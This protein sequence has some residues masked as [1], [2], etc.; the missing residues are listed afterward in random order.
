MN[1]PEIK[2]NFVPFPENVIDRPWPQTGDKPQEA[3]S[4]TVEEMSAMLLPALIDEMSDGIIVVGTNWHIA[5][6]NR[7]AATMCGFETEAV[8]G[9]NYH[10]CMPAFL[11]D[12]QA[13]EHA[14]KTKRGIKNRQGLCMPEHCHPFWITSSVHLLRHSMTS[15]LAGAIIKISRENPA[16]APS[17]T[18]A[19]SAFF[20]QLAHEF[21][22]P[23]GAI[24][25]FASLLERDLANEPEKQKLVRK[26]CECATSL[27]KITSSIALLARQGTIGASPSDL[28]ELFENAI[29]R[30]GDDLNFQ[31]RQITVKKVFPADKVI[32]NCDTGLFNEM[33]FRILKNLSKIVGNGDQIVVTLRKDTETSAL[34]ISF[35]AAASGWQASESDWEKKIQVGLKP[36]QYDFNHKIL[37][38]IIDLH[39]W[40]LDTFDYNEKRGALNIV[41][42]GE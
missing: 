6:C 18:K 11:D 29:G 14:V 26:I 23:L 37:T 32:I 31:A 15:E 21:R 9:R 28:K 42:P 41:I 8:V 33:I 24:Y 3:A 20:E 13:L 1:L 39:G 27:N 40:K 4:S 22:N 35:L 36:G 34:H 25:G 10:K 5:A 38:R 2:S 17:E 12:G 7:A 16:D 30:S 19:T